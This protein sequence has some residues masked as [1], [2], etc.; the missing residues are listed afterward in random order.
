MN[1]APE[2]AEERPDDL[3]SPSEIDLEVQRFVQDLRLIQDA[4]ASNGTLRRSHLH[5]RPSK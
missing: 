1:A 2:P 5:E 4:Q 3:G